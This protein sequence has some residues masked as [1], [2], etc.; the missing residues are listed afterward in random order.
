MYGIKVDTILSDKS[1]SDLNKLEMEEK[2]VT[3]D[4]YLSEIK[5]ISANYSIVHRN[6]EISRKGGEIVYKASSKE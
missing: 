5:E 1:D 6:Y 4:R 2:L 3:V